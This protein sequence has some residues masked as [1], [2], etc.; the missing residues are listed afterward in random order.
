MASRIHREVYVRF[1][2]EYGTVEV[3]DRLCLPHELENDVQRL[4]LL[5][6]SYDKQKYTLEDNF[7]I[8]YPKLIAASQEKLACVMED[9]KTADA[10]ILSEPDFAITVGNV[11]FDERVAGGTSMLEAVSKCKNGETTHLGTFKGFELMVEKNHIGV[12]YMVLRGKTDYK[13]ELS[14][15]PVGNMVKLEN[16]LGSIEENKGNL[17][18]RIEQYKRDMEQ[19]RMEYEKPFLQEQELNE[20]IAR[21]NELN[22]EL[23]LENG[24]ME[25]VDLNAQENIDDRVAEQGNY[26]MNK[27]PGKEGR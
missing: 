18:Q 22:V 9:I 5:K 16:L 15:S 2:R 4:K 20:K 10:G 23:D 1:W 27:P 6:F 14:S 19:S 3:D 7:L 11:R 12:H 25:D 13:A 8:R 24:K 17:E 21:L 26:Y